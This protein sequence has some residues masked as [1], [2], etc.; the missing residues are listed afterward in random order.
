[1]KYLLF[2]PKGDKKN[3]DG[4]VLSPP[5]A[6][7]LTCPPPTG[8]VGSLPEPSEPADAMPVPQVKIGPDGNIIINEERYIIII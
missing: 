1:M 6:T 8:T 2:R 3:E 7:T 5:K 4:E